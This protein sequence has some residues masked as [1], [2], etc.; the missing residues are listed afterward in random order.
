MKLR[1]RVVQGGRGAGG[2]R[3]RGAGGQRGRGAGEQ[4]GRGA[5]EA[6]EAGGD[7]EVNSSLP[8]SSLN[9]QA[10]FRF[11]NL[12]EHYATTRRTHLG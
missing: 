1:Q 4:R 7:R 6:G 11:G 8:H 5:G 10:S 12:Q 3:G 9:L 2:H